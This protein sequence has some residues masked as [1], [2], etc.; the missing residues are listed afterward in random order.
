M[1]VYLDCL[2]YIIECFLLDMPGQKTLN[3]IN[4]CPVWVLL[5]PIYYFAIT[6]ITGSNYGTDNIDS[7]VY[8]T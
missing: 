6:D 4:I 7:L 3:Y 8:H 5:L 2:T 1:C